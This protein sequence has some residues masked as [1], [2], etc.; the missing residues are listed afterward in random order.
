MLNFWLLKTILLTQI[1]KFL[2]QMLKLKS[3]PEPPNF[4]KKLIYKFWKKIVWSNQFTYNH[5]NW[6]TYS[7]ARKHFFKLTDGTHQKHGASNNLLKTN[8]AILRIEI[9]WKYTFRYCKYCP[10]CKVCRMQRILQYSARTTQRRIKKWQLPIWTRRRNLWPS[11]TRTKSYYSTAL[12]QF[13][14]K[15]KFWTRCVWMLLIETRFTSS[16]MPASSVSSGSRLLPN[17]FLNFSIKKYD[18]LILNWIQINLFKSDHKFR[19]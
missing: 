9:I 12:W 13:F 2:P 1:I 7:C 16:T 5:D 15:N 4:W 17:I 10:T 18:L 6:G 11:S 14:C 8:W 19:K 3:T